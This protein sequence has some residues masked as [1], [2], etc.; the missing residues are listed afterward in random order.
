MSL[1]TVPMQK[2]KREIVRQFSATSL[3]SLLKVITVQLLNFCNFVA[4]NQLFKLMQ[5]KGQNISPA[6]A[7]GKEAHKRLIK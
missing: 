5:K 4:T 2:K 7:A 3:F 6:A 1:A